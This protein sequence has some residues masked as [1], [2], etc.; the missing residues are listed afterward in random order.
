MK[1]ILIIDDNDSFRKVLSMRLGKRGFRVKDVAES[2]KGL[3]LITNEFFDIIITDLVMKDKDGIQ[4]I[5]EARVS[6]PASIIILITAY[7]SVDTAVQ[8]IKAGAYDYITKESNLDE[9]L[10]VIDRAMEKKSLMDKIQVL[11]NQIRE[12]FDFDEIIGSSPKM[13]EVLKT[14]SKVSTTQ[15]T[16]LITGQSGTG[17]ELVGKA[18]HYNSPRKNKSL[19]TINC[20]AIPENLQESE[21][22]GYKKGAFTGAIQDK[23]GLIEEA[24]GGTLILDE[25]GEL[26]PTAQ[27]KLLRFLQNNEVRRVGDTKTSIVDVRIIA[28]TN[29]NLEDEVKNNTFREDLFFRLNVVPIILPSLSERPGDIEIMLEHFVKKIGKKLHMTKLNITPEAVRLLKIYHWPGNI[30]ELENVLERCAILCND[31][32]IY[33]DDL[34]SDIQQKN[35]NNEPE[36]TGTHL[37]LQEIEKKY[38]LSVLDSTNGN[39]SHAA[40]ILQI[41]RPTLINKL[42]SYNID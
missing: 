2:I 29:R 12:Q 20:G 6:S 39:K 31:E 13:I 19:V 3:E 25:V 42:K 10:L 21:L 26:S 11:E 23:K 33:P 34:P 8:A 15:A 24:D 41:S 38:I 5:Q 40:D 35:N 9:I 28:M 32:T 16:V 7:G 14:I 1:S 4:V 30:R 18:I 36:F 17:K 37:S 27:V 22:F